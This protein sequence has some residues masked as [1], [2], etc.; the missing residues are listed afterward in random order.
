[1]CQVLCW[2]VYSLSPHSTN[3]ADVVI[4]LKMRFSSV[5]SLTRVWHFV[6]PWTTARQASL[7]IIIS[8]SSL[9]LTSI[10][11]VMLHSAFFTVQLSHPYM[12][13]GKAIA[14]TRWP[15]VGKQS[16]EELMLL[17]CGLGED[18]W[19]SLGLQGDPTNPF[20]RRSALGF[21]WKEWC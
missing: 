10:E 6:T 15:L 19:E 1:M 13:T 18:S 3:G 4:I 7:S 9:R 8:R 12:T 21:L 11:S 20:W 14:L 17:N 2:V 16:A 5:Q